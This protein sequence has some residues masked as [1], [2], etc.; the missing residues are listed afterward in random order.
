MQKSAEECKRVRK[1]VKRKELSKAAS[2]EWRG[3]VPDWELLVYMPAV[4]VR[5]ASKGFRGYGNLAAENPGT[6]SKAAAC[7]DAKARTSRANVLLLQRLAT[8]R[9]LH[10][11]ELPASYL[12]RFYSSCYCGS[13]AANDGPDV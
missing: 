4:F 11:N 9:R 13:M 12:D 1:S 3:R 5:V 10:F 8:R 6:L 7:R 2:A